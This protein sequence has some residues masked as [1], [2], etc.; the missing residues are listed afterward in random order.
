MP[1]SA[2]EQP[3]VHFFADHMRTSRHFSISGFHRCRGFLFSS[4]SAPTFYFSASSVHGPWRS[5]RPL[6][7]LVA[8]KC[9]FFRPTADRDPFSGP[10]PQRTE[11]C[12]VDVALT[13]PALTCASSAFSTTENVGQRGNPER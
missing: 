4:F 9:T 11:N 8:E 13:G 3:A 12:R 5:C 7:K 6:G 2:L 10:Q 1:A